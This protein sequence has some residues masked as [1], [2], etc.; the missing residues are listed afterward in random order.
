MQRLTVD[1]RASLE[2]GSDRSASG[3]AGPLRQALFQASKPVARL[4]H[5]LRVVEDQEFLATGVAPQS[6][7]LHELRH[8]LF[9]LSLLDG[10]GS[11]RSE[12]LRMDP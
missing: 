9:R 4:V 8:S 12:L 1:A 10:Y 6:A 5:G 3:P 7:H 11:H 2:A